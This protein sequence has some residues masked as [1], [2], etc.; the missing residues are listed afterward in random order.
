MVQEKFKPGETGLPQ[1]PIPHW[2]HPKGDRLTIVS[3]NG[4][5]VRD[6]EGTEYLDF[7]AQLY[8]VNAG[9]DNERIISAIEEQLRKIPYV[10]PAKHNE[11]RTQLAEKLTS[12]TPGGLNDVYFAISGS[13]AN[14]IAMSLARKVQDAPKV[15]TRWQS[16]HGGT[17]G[18]GSYTGDP[19]TRSE[20]ERYAA[21]TNAGKFLPPLP[22]A[23]GTDD[24]TELADRAAQHVEYVLRNENPEEV[25]AILMEPIGGSSGAF[26]APPGYFSQLREICDAHDVLLVSDEV[27]TGFGRCGEWFGVQ[28]EHVEPDMITFAKGITSAYIPL[29]GVLINEDI[30]KD[31]RANQ[32]G[33]GQT[34][35]GHP[36]ACAAGLAALDVYSEGLLQNV[37]DLEPHLAARLQEVEEKYDVVKT[38]RGR[39]FL[40]SVVFAEPST[41]KPF[42]DPWTEDAS[43][44][45]VS[46]VR[47]TAQNEGVIFGSG[48]PEIQTLLCPPLCVTQAEI[49]YAIDTL[50]SAIERVFH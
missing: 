2:Y 18:A 13:E 44:N 19:A 7:L 1:D 30:A 33:V 11:A 37:R 4:A 25:A 10:S 35:A 42:V 26:P 17:Y 41:G 29:A 3:G 40:W 14:E 8:C 20:I 46:E 27:I 48:R 12:V 45:P 22:N 5:T 28:T 43:D 38:V 36:A 24:P 9:Y 39:G 21:T 23:F 32:F 6:E 31:I 47:K 15:L 50:E 34:F 49:D 16:Y